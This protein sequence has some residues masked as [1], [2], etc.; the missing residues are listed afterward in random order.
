MR[1]VIAILLLAVVS[2]GLLARSFPTYADFTGQGVEVVGGDTITILR[3]RRPIKVRLADIDAPK[4]L[5]EFG[6]R[7]GQSLSEVCFDTTA[8]RIALVVPH[9][10]DRWTGR[11]SIF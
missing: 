5:Q 9:R 4:N 11:V 1:N 8:G 3:E 10:L 7:F 6:T 2:G